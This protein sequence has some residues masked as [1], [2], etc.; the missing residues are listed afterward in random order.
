MRIFA[1]LL[2]SVLVASCDANRDR[3]YIGMD[4]RNF[5]GTIAEKLA[6]AVIREDVE[7]I[8]EEVTANNIPVDYKEP[9]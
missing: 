7:D 6:K 4:Y 1:I 9:N 5:N 2:L 3:H 8:R